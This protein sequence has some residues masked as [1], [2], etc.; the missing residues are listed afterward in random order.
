MLR[1]LVKMSTIMLGRF[2]SRDIDNVTSVN[3]ACNF[4][5]LFQNVL[6]TIVGFIYKPT[7]MLLQTGL[8]N[9]NKHVSRGMPLSL[10][11][12]IVTKTLICCT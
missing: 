8:G 7:I 9:R 1:A 4:P 2:H 11:F 12:P 10:F 6:S 3:I 5:I